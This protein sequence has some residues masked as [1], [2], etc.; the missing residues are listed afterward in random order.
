MSG[1]NPNLFQMFGELMK[2]KKRT[3]S[4]DELAREN[5]RALRSVHTDATRQFT[6]ILRKLPAEAPQGQKS[7][8]IV[9]ERLLTN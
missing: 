5:S 7:G 2:C 3:P 4:G 6:R 9:V 8:H 1:K